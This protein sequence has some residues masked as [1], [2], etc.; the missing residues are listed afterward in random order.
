M[1]LKTLID[2]NSFFIFSIF[3]FSTV[4]NYYY[5]SLG[6]FPLD[7]FFHFDLGYRILEG[8]VPFTDIWM[9]S[10]VLVNYIQA[11]FFYILGINWT[12]YVFHASLING[13]ISVA[14]YFVL[15]N[16]NLNINYCFIYS[17]L[18]SILGY[19]SSGTPFVDHHSAFFSLIGVYSLLLAIKSEK[20]IFWILLPIFMGFGFLSKQVPTS[21]VIFSTTIII[22]FYSY[23]FKKIEYIKHILIG[24]LIFVFFVFLFGILNGIRFENFIQQYILY[25]QTIGDSR[26]ENLNLTFRGTVDHFK[27]IYLSIAPIFFINFKK[28]IYET[29][30]VKKKNFFYFTIILFFTLSLIF[31]QLL[32]KNQTFIFFLI[33]LLAAFSHKAIEETQLRKKN[34]IF[35]F[36]VIYCVLVTSKYHIRFNE[37]RKFH[38]L[39]KVDFS[40]SIEATKI[41]KKLKGLKWIS[42]EY[43]NDVE[44][45][46]N[47][48]NRIKNHLKSD[49]RKK[50]VITN[51]SFFSSILNE[52]LFS[53]SMAYTDDGTTYPLKKSKYYQ[54]YKN[55]IIE[56]IK[57]NNVEVIYIIDPVK[58]AS[59]Y[60][61]LDQSCFK[62]KLIFE[63]LNS[64]ELKNCKDLK[65]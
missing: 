38:E 13:L 33:P 63:K 9:V 59:I 62:E 3:I 7:T 12:S 57:K 4:I 26:L 2:R 49:K 39:S 23:V 36:L 29:G 6:A 37:G 35:I 53:P 41:H 65:G 44:D 43:K 47:L 52:K 15:K 24:S 25:P 61:Y 27:F 56:V 48:I 64:Y 20:K 51:Y 10:G 28:I 55:L 18:F 14:T 21:Y 32:T 8:E 58:K 11:F 17:L 40:K 34:L 31:H 19:T 1:N 16:F 5:A 60:D 50:M 42:P 45:E 22:L 30:Y 46:I 54:E